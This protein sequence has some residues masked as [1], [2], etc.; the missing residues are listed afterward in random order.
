M[1][2]YAEK[3]AEARNSVVGHSGPY[4]TT[5]R[6]LADLAEHLVGLADERLEMVLR[7]Q[8]RYVEDTDALFLA[9]K[10]AERELEARE[11]HHFETEALLTQ[12]GINPDAQPEWEYGVMGP[13]NRIVN[14]GDY[15]ILQTHRR[16]KA[17]PWLPV[18]PSDVVPVPNHTNRTTE[19][20]R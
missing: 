9:R 11:L 15:R 3:I 16:L 20:A 12:A 4:S 2:D 5:I 19:D 6:Y 18:E 8:K 17:G 1:S 7:E 14:N 10:A 13:L